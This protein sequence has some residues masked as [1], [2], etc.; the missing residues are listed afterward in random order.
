MATEDVQGGN[1]G[2]MPSPTSSIT[3]SIKQKEPANK[4]HL[5]PFF[6]RCLIEG[7]DEI[8]PTW[9][10]CNKCD[11]R[12]WCDQQKDGT[13]SMWAHTHKCTKH[14]LHVKIDPTPSNLCKNNI[15]EAM[16]YHKYN[17]KRCDEWCI[18]III[19]DELPF[20]CA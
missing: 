13:S 9:C 20:R 6:T 11:E 15:S 4:S 18:D 14:P 10:K 16:G 12:V 5:W 8:D 17:N 1:V 3:G 7:S 2:C 19:I